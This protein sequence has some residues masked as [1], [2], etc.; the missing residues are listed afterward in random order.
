MA[1]ERYKSA[2]LQKWLIDKALGVSGPY[3]RRM[4]TS[5]DQRSR[6]E[7]FVGKLYFFRYDPLH[8]DKLSEYDKFPMCFPL[9]PPMT[10][11][12]GLSFLGLNLHYLTGYEREKLLNRLLEYK[13]NKY[14]DH[15]T[16]LNLSYQLINSTRSLNS[17]ARPCIKRY[18]FSHVRSKFIEIYPEEYMIAAQL[19]V[20]DWVFNQ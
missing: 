3:A 2:D 13:N 4:I 16:R 15:R 8:K 7:T 19:P 14:M 5:N 11:K 6:D 12:N 9:E 17:L 10:V 1:T 20:A 18:L